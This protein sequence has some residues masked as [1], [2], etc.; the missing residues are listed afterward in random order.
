[1]NDFDI[2]NLTEA[3][4]IELCGEE[5]VDKLS[6]KNCDFSG[7]TTPDGLIEFTASIQLDD[8]EDYYFLIAHYYQTEE[9]VENAEELDQLEWEIDHYSVS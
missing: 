8:H 3:Q 4:T 2:D 6:Y 9:D 7:C 5:I 1:M